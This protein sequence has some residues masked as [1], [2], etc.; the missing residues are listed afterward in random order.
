MPTL[1]AILLVASLALVAQTPAPPFRNSLAPGTD[2]DSPRARLVAEIHGTRQHLKDLEYLSDTFGPRLTTSPNLR[3][4]QA[5][6][7]E[8][9]HAYGATNVHEEAYAFGLPWTRGPEGGQLLGENP[10]P[11]PMQQM[12]WTQATPGTVKGTLV[13]VDARTMEELQRWKGQLKGR[14]VMRTLPDDPRPPVPHHADGD[15]ARAE[16]AA[17]GTWLLWEGALAAFTMSGKK[18]GLVLMRGGEGRDPAQPQVPTAILP[19]ETYRTLHRLVTSGKPQQV[20]VNLGG[21]LGT[22][23]VEAH[24]VV[25]DLPGTDKAEEVVILGG[26]FD[27]WDLG[28]GTLDNGTGAIMALEVLRAI[29]ACGLKP[30]RTLRVV[31][32]TG[33]EQGLV[34]AR[35]HVAAH[36]KD[37]SR[38]QA[39][40]N[41]DTGTGHMKGLNLWGR[42]D[43]RP[44][45]GAL[46]TSVHDLGI[47]DLPVGDRRLGYS[48]HAPYGWA[49]VPSF[50]AM[51]DGTNYGPAY[52]SLTDTFDKVLPDAWTQ[53]IQGMAVLTWE[54]LNMDQKLP[55]VPAIDK[56]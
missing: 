5:W 35:A 15:V 10:R 27:S 42:E 36:A 13:V 29:R 33:E 51:V 47:K 22:H 11:I 8:K 3:R 32:W 48:D 20:E 50:V 17:M 25:A 12:A 44:T 4:A 49:G 24:N 46:M 26:H 43:L 21:Q 31:L 56:R 45:L 2:P 16:G 23:P 41:Q 34:G 19:Q 30:R 14:V 7:Q 38:I 28:T 37:L 40:L 39:V 1:R 9:L 53:M 52:H 18:E 6:I 54:L 55:Q